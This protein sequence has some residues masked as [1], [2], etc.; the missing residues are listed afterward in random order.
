[1]PGLVFAQQRCFLRLVR[2]DFSGDAGC[3]LNA[4]KWPHVAVQCHVGL[5][6]HLPDVSISIDHIQHLSA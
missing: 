1:M 4:T 2:S 3:F 6:I 5:G